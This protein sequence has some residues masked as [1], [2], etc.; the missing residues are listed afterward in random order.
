[1]FSVIDLVISPLA[2]ILSYNWLT[3]LSIFDSNHEYLVL[4]L[5]QTLVWFLLVRLFN[6]YRFQFNHSSA[7]ILVD[8]FKAWLLYVPALVFSIYL[9]RLNDIRDDVFLLFI[10]LNFVLIYSS[11]I[12]IN[13]L[14]DRMASRVSHNRNL[15]V[16]A[17][18]KSSYVIDS[19]LNTGGAGFVINAIVCDSPVIAEMYGHKITILA[20]NTDIRNYL[21]ENPIHELHYCKDNFIMEELRNLIYA[22]QEVGVTFRMKSI[23]FN[24]LS[25]SSTIYYLGNIPFITVSNLPDNYLHLQIKRIMD[26]VISFFAIVLSFP[27]MLVIALLIKLTSKGPV[28]FTQVR[29]GLRGRKFRLFKFR[30]MIVHSNELREELESQN[31]MDGPVFKIKNDPRIT[32]LGLFLRKTSLDEFP[33]FLNVLRGEMSVV[34]PRPPIPAEV[35]QYEVW[36]L[37]RISIKPG[38]TCIWQVSGRNN[39][40]FDEWMRQD[41]EYIDNW[42]LKLDLVI[43]LKTIKTMLSMNGR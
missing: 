13:K 36:Q 17:D 2:L 4:I 18:E 3:G 7:E 5:V 23:L 11:R 6:I 21:V 22:C 8:Y 28:L 29:S 24:T 37:R 41:L 33:Q 16:I 14:F 10:G 39:T 38:I 9:F 19:L 34:G 1:M 32:R 25:T 31:E 12:I 43:C 27:L 42:S 35:K 30:T 26:L 15:V 40:T 20:E